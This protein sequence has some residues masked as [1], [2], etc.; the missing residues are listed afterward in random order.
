MTKDYVYENGNKVRHFYTFNS[1][2]RESLRFTSTQL[3]TEVYLLDELEKQE[4]NAKIELRKC[5]LAIERQKQ[6]IEQHDPGVTSED[7]V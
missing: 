6:V 4:Q 3:L 5:Q 1:G 2:H 7:T